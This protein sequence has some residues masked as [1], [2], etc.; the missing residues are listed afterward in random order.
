MTASKG[1]V[2]DVRRTAPFTVGISLKMYFGHAETLDW[3]KRVGDLAREHPAVRN[4]LV[5]LF[6]IPSFPAI[7]PVRDVLRGSGVAIGA[8]DLFWAD[9]GPYTGEVSGSELAELGCSLVEIGHAE[10]RALFHEDEIVISRKV[11]AAYRNRLLPLLCV[12]EEREESAVD[13]ADEV[14]RQISSAL[15][16]SDAAGL[17]GPLLVAYEPRWAIGAP[18]PASPA[19]IAEVVQGIHRVLAG[20]PVRAGSRVIYGGSAGPGLL[21][22]LGG[23]VPGLF[24]GRFAHDPAAIGLVLDEAAALA[25]AFLDET[26]STD[27]RGTV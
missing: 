23:E 21:T 11:A 19:Y 1:N 17:A 26:A 12:G 6:V 25:A 14:G 9:R 5:S 4:G 18:A 2:A 24:L 27:E 7:V 15:R 3:A 16:D 13:A 10:R 20:L 22:E 8:Q